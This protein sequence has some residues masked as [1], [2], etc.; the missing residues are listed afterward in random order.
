MRD[1][2][3][4]RRV[5]HE[6][7]A[8]RRTVIAQLASSDQGPAWGRAH[9]IRQKMAPDIRPSLRTVQSV[10]REFF[11]TLDSLAH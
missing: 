7:A 3:N 5:R 6:N 11:S 9:R 8:V 4:A 10:L 2:A 1:P